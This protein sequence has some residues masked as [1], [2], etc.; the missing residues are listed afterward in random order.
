LILA[1]GEGRRFGGPKQLALLNDRPLLEYAVDAMRAVPTIAPVVVVL[2]AYAEQIRATI[3]SA[4]VHIVVCTNWRDGIAASLRAGLATVPYAEAVIVTLGDQP[5]I[6]SEAIA[7]LAN[8][9]GA[10]R[11]TYGGVPGHPVR[12]TAREIAMTR[13]LQGDVGARPLL[14][15]A[16]HVECGDLCD[17]ADVDTIEELYVLQRDGTVDADGAFG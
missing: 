14:A 11:A 15:G 13:D 8:D 3:D 7:R 4:D 10:A 1:A 12:L 6:T 5:R 2:G 9:H 16:S 17:P